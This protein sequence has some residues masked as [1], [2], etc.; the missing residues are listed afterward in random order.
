M[1]ISMTLSHCDGDYMLVEGSTRD[2]YLRKRAGS[3]TP[4]ATLVQNEISLQPLGGFRWND[5][6]YI[7]IQDVSCWL[8]L[9]HHHEFDILEFLVEYLNRN[10]MD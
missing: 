8:F 10:W 5:V 1:D 7:T 4:A 6:Q 9:Q 2:N 3:V